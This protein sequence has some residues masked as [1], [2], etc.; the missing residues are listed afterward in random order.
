MLLVTVISPFW[1]QNQLQGFHF[2]R[3][4][5]KLKWFIPLFQKIY[6]VETKVWNDL[7]GHWFHNF[8]VNWTKLR[9]LTIESSISYWI[10]PLTL[11]N[12]ESNDACTAKKIFWLK[13]DFDPLGTMAPPKWSNLLRGQWVECNFWWIGLIY[14][15]KQQRASPTATDPS[16]KVSNGLISFIRGS[17]YND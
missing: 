12:F 15:T 10:S 7:L 14:T 3:N 11:Q 17:R 1:C 8:F 16:T 5:S 13:L 6:D 2:E 9:F 4:E